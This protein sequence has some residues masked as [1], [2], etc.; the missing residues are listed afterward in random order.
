MMG[1]NAFV[2]SMY[3]T[4]TSNQKQLSNCF[5]YCLTDCKNYPAMHNIMLQTDCSNVQ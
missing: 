1:F 2:S 3:N 5:T 4:S